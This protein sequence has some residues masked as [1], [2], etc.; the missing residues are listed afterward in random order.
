MTQAIAMQLRRAVRH[1][2]LIIDEYCQIQQAQ[3]LE[4]HWQVKCNNGN[5]YECDA[6]LEP[7]CDRIWLCTGNKFDVAAESL[8]TEILDNYPIP[9]V[10]GLPVLDTHLR[11]PGCELFLMGALAALQVGLTARNLSGARMASEKIVPAIVKSSLAYGSQRE[12]SFS[13]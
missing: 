10:Q 4:H 6:P 9:I 5:E 11:W 1:G 12:I 2:N 13:R 8:L 3:W 7:L